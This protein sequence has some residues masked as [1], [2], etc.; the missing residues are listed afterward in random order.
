[1][2]IECPQCWNSFSGPKCKCGYVPKVER[3][4]AER[5]MAIRELERSKTEEAKDWLVHHKIVCREV[6]G[7]ERRQALQAY[8]RKLKTLPKPETYA[9]AYEIL[10][11]IADGEIV[12]PLMH[13]MATEVVENHK[14]GNFKEAA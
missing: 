12:T 7:A 10:S 2:T 8:M 11:R 13:K 4:P 1:M 9:W 3:S 6:K 5:S 14:R